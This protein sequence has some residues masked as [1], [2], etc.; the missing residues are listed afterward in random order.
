MKAE[1]GRMKS[2][3]AGTGDVSTFLRHPVAKICIVA[4]LACAIAISGAEA[5]DK[6]RIAVSN[7]NMPNLTVAIAQQKGFFK[8]ENIEAEIIRMNPNVAVTA[9]ATGDVDYCQ[10]FGAVVG[11][12][13]AGLPIRIVAGYLDNWPMTLIAQPEFKT[14]KD[15]R[16]KTLGISSFG[17]TPDLAARMMLKQ[18][19]IDPEKRSRYWRWAPMRR[20]LQRSSRG[21]WI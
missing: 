17:A 20:D 1:S 10:L 7:P 9:L 14:L 3:P 13:I 4:L 8:D 11:G 21:W 5:L 15:L 2:R 18:V 19:G 12:A 16:G 6:V